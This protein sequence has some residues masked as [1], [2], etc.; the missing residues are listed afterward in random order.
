[1]A[2]VA[3][4]LYC[5]FGLECLDGL[6]QRELVRPAVLLV[7]LLRNDASEL[8]KGFEHFHDVVLLQNGLNFLHLL[9]ATLQ[10]GVPLLIALAS[11]AS[12]L[13][14]PHN[15]LPLRLGKVAFRL[16][17]VEVVIALPRWQ[18]EEAFGLLIGREVLYGLERD[19]VLWGRTEAGF[20]LLVEHLTDSICNYKKNKAGIHNQSY[21]LLH[22]IHNGIIK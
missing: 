4:L 22:H 3:C 21:Y 14:E 8:L 1:M 16:L 7:K 20:L 10:F 11:L 13:R 18:I 6:D 17:L 15:H 2:D 9:V 12:A 5:E 19:L